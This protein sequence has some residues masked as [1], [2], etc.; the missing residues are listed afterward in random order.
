MQ[1]SKVLTLAPERTLAIPFRSV[2]FRSLSTPWCFIELSLEIIFDETEI[3]RKDGGSC[4]LYARD[5][6]KRSR[7]WMK[8]ETLNCYPLKSDYAWVCR[9]LESLNIFYIF[10]FLSVLFLICVGSAISNPRVLSKN[11]FETLLFEKVIIAKI[12]F[13][14][15]FRILD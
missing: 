13:C 10:F 1:I 12:Y 11:R 4:L 5:R 9:E 2:S 8:R 3:Q 6:W 14:V 7:K 15:F